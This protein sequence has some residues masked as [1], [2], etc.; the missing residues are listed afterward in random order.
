MQYYNDVISPIKVLA[1]FNQLYSPLKFKKMKLLLKL[2]FIIGIMMS[3]SF[4]HAQTDIK[5]DLVLK[6]QLMKMDGKLYLFITDEKGSPYSNKD[7]TATAKIKDINNK[8]QNVT[9]NTFGESA[10]VFNNE[11][12]NFKKINAT[13][14][15]KNGLNP[16]LIYAKF[17]NN[18]SSEN[19]Y[20]CSMHPSELFKDAGTC[21]KCGM[22]LAAKQVTTYQPSK[23]VRKGSL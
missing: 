14:R 19:R 10:F 4:L 12:S 20:E 23:I 1:I 17:K 21:T 16:L 18:G 22:S 11:I 3:M 2:S 7:V 5:S 9:L 13:L 6:A 15:F 8:T